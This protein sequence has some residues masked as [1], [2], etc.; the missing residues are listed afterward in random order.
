MKIIRNFK[1][2]FKHWQ[3]YQKVAHDNNCWK[4]RFL[5]HDIEKPFFQIFF[6]HKFVSKWHRKLNSHHAE[7]IFPNCI[8]YLGMVID[9]ECARYTKPEEQ[10]NARQTLENYYP[11]LKSKV[12]PILNKL[13]L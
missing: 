7:F 6:S 13:N 4:F 5:F 10:L 11:N 12:E 9:W 1:Y 8:D 2:W 3:A